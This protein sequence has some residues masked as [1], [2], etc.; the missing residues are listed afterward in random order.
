MIE[1]PMINGS[2]AH[3]FATSALAWKTKQSI[4]NRM[5]I[6]IYIFDLDLIRQFIYLILSDNVNQ[7]IIIMDDHIKIY[8]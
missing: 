1:P 7:P 2:P 5:Y 8:K 4:C 3:A 6:Y